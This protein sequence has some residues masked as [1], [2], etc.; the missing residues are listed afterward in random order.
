M[1]GKR[2][3][4]LATANVALA[5][6]LAGAGCSFDHTGVAATDAGEAGDGG[7]AACE[8]GVDD[9]GDGRIDFP[10]DPGCERPADDDEANAM[11]AQC[12]DGLDNDSD[13]AID[14]PADFGCSSAL[15]DDETDALPACSNGLDDDGD[16]LIDWVDAD[17]DGLPDMGSDPGC[18]DPSDFDETNGLPACA[19]GLDDDGD[20][21]IDFPADPGCSD[22]ADGDETDVAPAACGDGADND[23][24]ALTD[25]PADP[26][27]TSAGDA[28]ET[29]PPPDCGGVGFAGDVS[30]TGVAAGTTSG[31]SDFSGSCAGTTAPEDVYLFELPY[32]VDSLVIDS[33]GSLTSALYVRTTC[34]DPA[35][36]LQCNDFG[37]TPTLFF[38]PLGAGTYFV[39]V[40]GDMGASGP[41]TVSL[42]GQWPALGPCAP[43]H[44]WIDCPSGETCTDPGTGI[45]TCNEGAC[46]DGFDN[47]GDAIVDWPADPGCTAPDDASELD[48]AGG[49]PSCANASDDDGDALA[50]Y[51]DDL[52]CLAASDASEAG[53]GYG[54]EGGLEGWTVANSDAT[55]GWI[56]DSTEAVSPPNALY[57]GDPMALSYDTGMSANDGTATSPMI[58]LSAGAPALTFFVW[59]DVEN[60]Q[61]FDTLQLSV[62]PAGTV[63]WTRN[64]FPQGAM[65]STGGAFFGQLVDLSAFAGTTIQLQFAFDTIDGI[66]NDFQGVYIDR[67]AIDGT[68]P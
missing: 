16:A 66:F 22:G 45:P 11:D 32:A 62:L 42:S 31:S 18:D 56:V 40:D 29:D 53:C 28:D 33:G 52:G 23:G 47:D 4:L 19:N 68:C 24:D 44:A 54:F 17:G 51:P 36:E 6:L 39:F 1:L 60:I 9:D 61:T 3:S 34:D 50:D 25:F 38:G 37:M 64:D 2:A 57:Y 59:L 7:A 46:R 55:V 30:V 13:G 48:P 12:M 43:G 14:F 65:G 5:G 63:V 67:V 20:A 15:D 21:L 49:P 35:T 58:T 27:C 8:N 10:D 26:G 41:Y